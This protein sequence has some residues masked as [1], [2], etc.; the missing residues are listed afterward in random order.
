[1]KNRSPAHRLIQLTRKT[2]KIIIPKATWDLSNKENKD[3]SNR[4]DP[5][6]SKPTSSKKNSIEK[7]LSAKK[8]ENLLKGSLKYLVGEKTHKRKEKE[9]SKS[10]SHHNHRKTEISQVG[11]NKNLIEAIS[12]LTNKIKHEQ[13]FS[14]VKK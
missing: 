4:H 11:S 2:E 14:K 10:K 1:M 12:S 7:K 9:T 5:Y 13:D 3:L 8:S 6:S